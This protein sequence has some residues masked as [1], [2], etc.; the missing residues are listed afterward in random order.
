MKTRRGFN[1]LFK[2]K[3]YSMSIFFPQSKRQKKNISC[4]RKDV[5]ATAFF[6]YTS[7]SIQCRECCHNRTFS[8]NSITL[9]RHK[10]TSG[11]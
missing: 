8:L 2:M 5:L 3:K 11:Q 10:S 6:T 7:V 1:L 9:Q 4:L